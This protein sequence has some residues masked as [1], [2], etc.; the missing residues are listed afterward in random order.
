MAF[1][2]SQLSEERFEK[3]AY[4]HDRDV[5]AWE[6][7]NVTGLGPLIPVANTKANQ[8]CVYYRFGVFKFTVDKNNTITAGEAVYYDSVNMVVQDT[9]PGTGFYLGKA[10]SGGTGNATGTVSVEVSLN[11][12]PAIAANFGTENITTSGNI[13]CANVTASGD[14]TC[15]DLTSSGIVASTSSQVIGIAKVKEVNTTATLTAGDVIGGIVKSTPEA[16][17][18]LTLPGADALLALVPGAV[19]GTTVKFKV[20]NCAAETHIIRLV[21]SASITNGG[22][23][24]HL[25][26]APATAASFEIVFTNVT[27]SVAAELYRG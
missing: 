22:V 9:L 8:L 11:D 14:I 6:P 3:I 15:D 27:D 12:N 25:D 5:N 16:N 10:L 26:V 19:V 17:I 1:T 24:A 13:T 7:I 21:A 4:K 23:A 2:V 20:V 18:D